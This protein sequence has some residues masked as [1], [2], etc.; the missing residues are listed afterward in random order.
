MDHASS[1]QLDMFDPNAELSAIGVTRNQLELWARSGYISFD[2]AVPILERWMLQETA[3]IHHLTKVEWSVNAL[4]QL[5]AS[6]RRP[7]LLDHGRHFFNFKTL[8]WERRY[9]PQ[10]LLETAPLEKPAEIG[11][12]IRAHIRQLALAGA[13]VEVLKTLAVL[14]DVLPD[15]WLLDLLPP[16]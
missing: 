2:P 16:E 7:Y 12:M 6:I 5:L 10:D 9:G 4:R 11:N 1:S 8:E 14:R 3:F 13:R 15:D